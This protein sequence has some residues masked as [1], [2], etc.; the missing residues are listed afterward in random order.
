MPHFRL[1]TEPGRRAAAR[2]ARSPACPTDQAERIEQIVKQA[3]RAARNGN[4]RHCLVLAECI[5]DESPTPAEIAKAKAEVRAG[6]AEDTANQPTSETKGK[7]MLTLKHVGPEDTFV[8]EGVTPETPYPDAVIEQSV[9]KIWEFV[10]E[11]TDTLDSDRCTAMIRAMID[12]VTDELQGEL[13]R[14]DKLRIRANTIAR[15]RAK[16]IREL[17]RKAKKP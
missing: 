2:Y 11:N 17:E 14:M 7:T 3:R 8:P 12:R 15:N 13:Q 4:W 10:R 6:W 5:R 16:R 9:W 1:I